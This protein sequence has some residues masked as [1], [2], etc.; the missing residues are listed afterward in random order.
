M[1]EEDVVAE[2]QR[3]AVV[4][5]EVAADDEGLGEAA[6]RRLDGIGEAE[7]EAL[8]VAEQPLKPGEIVRAW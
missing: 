1:A 7:P 6:R 3:D 2:N 4:A 5:D 8:A